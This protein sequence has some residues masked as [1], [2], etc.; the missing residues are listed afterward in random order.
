MIHFNTIQ[1]NTTKNNTKQQLPS[2]LLPES[3]NVSLRCQDLMIK[4]STWNMPVF[5]ELFFCLTPIYSKTI[6]N[7]DY[8][9]I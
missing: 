6:L 7:S 2:L 3:L 1:Y 9:L 4:L 5:I 8:S